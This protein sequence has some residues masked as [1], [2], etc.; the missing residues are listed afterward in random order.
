MKTPC[1]ENVLKLLWNLDFE[2]T[3]DD[4]VLRMV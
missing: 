4:K 1:V 3:T 2:M